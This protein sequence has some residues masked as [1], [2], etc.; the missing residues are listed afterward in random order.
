MIEHT[1]SDIS[2]VISKRLVKQEDAAL[3]EYIRQQCE[4]IVEKGGKLEDYLLVREQ[5][6]LTY[7]GGTTVKSG[8]SYGLKHRDNVKLVEIKDES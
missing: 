3:S 7:D 2:K 6:Q 8:V 5:G 4:Q 1:L